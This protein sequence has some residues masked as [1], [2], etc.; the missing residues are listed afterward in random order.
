MIQSAH[1]D[2]QQMIEYCLLFSDNN[3][4][5]DEQEEKREKKEEG[6]E[7][8]SKCSFYCDISASNRM[9][10][11]GRKEYNHTHYFLKQRAK[12][13]QSTAVRTSLQTSLSSSQAPLLS[14]CPLPPC[15]VA[16]L[17]PGRSLVHRT[18]APSPWLQ[19]V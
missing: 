1:L 3:D 19:P 11:E 6:R 4:D 9:Y 8:E 17:L 13:D 16:W 10:D 7:E 15:I 14:S 12:G 2:Y 5:E 18:G